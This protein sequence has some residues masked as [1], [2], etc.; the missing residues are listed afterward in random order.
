MAGYMKYFGDRVHTKGDYLTN[1]G[2]YSYDLGSWHMVALNSQLCRGTTYD[3]ATGGRMQIA[4]NPNVLPGCGPGDSEYEWLRADLETHP[5]QCTLVYYHHP[6]L[7]RNE[8][9]PTPYWPGPMY[10]SMLPL[11][12]LM[13]S[14]GVDVVLNGHYHSYQRFTPQNEYG[15]PVTTGITEFIVGTGGSTHE[16]FSK[17]YAPPPAFAAGTDQSFGILDMTLSDGGWSYAF[18]TAAGEPAFQDAG[19]GTCH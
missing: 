19:T 13:A 17:K 11:W 8:Y 12:R 3:Y 7:V 18:K 5:S 4:R 1:A 15:Q 10:Y 14:H 2:F 6:M 9:A 16:Y